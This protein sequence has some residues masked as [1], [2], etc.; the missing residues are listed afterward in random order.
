MIKSKDINERRIIYYMNMSSTK[1]LHR[2]SAYVHI[3]AL[4]RYHN[5][6]LVAKPC[7]NCGYDKHVEI[8]HIKPISEFDVNTKIKEVNSPDNLVQLCPN[9]HW[10]FDNL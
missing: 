3:R 4:A 5:K 6:E 7:N 9:C 8:C 10:E 1:N 2:S